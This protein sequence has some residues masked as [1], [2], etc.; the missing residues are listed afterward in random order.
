MKLFYRSIIVLTFALFG[1]SQ[2]ASATHIS[3]GDISYTCVGQDSFLVTL[4][5]FRDCAGVGL[6]TSQS[7]RFTST[8]G[9]NVTLSLQEISNNEISQLCPLQI[10]NSTCSPGGSWPGMEEHVYEGIVVLSPPCNSWTMTWSSCCRNNQISNLTNPGTLG[11]FLYNEMFSGVDTCNTSPKFTS[12]PIPYVCKNQVVNYNFGVYEPD[13]DS[14]VYFMSPGYT[15]NIT[16]TTPYRGT[17]TYLQPLPG[18][19]AVFDPTNGQLTFTPTATGVY[20][21]VVVIEEYDRLTGVAKGT[22]IRDIQVVVQNCTNNQPIVSS[23]GIK[24]FT[25]TGTQIDSNTI[26]LCIG[27]NFAFDYEIGDADSNNTITI[28]HNI[29]NALDSSANVTITNGNPAVIHVE[30]TAPG[31]F[32]P[33][34]SFSITGIDDACP[35]VG[36]VSGVINVRV[37]PSTYAGLDTSICVGTQ[38]VDLNVVGGAP[39]AW[40]VVSGS[41][42]DTNVNSPNFNMTCFNC[43]NPSVSPQVTTTY[44]VL[45]TSQLQGGCKQID[46][47]TVQ[48]FPNFEITMPNDTLICPIDSINLPV[49]ADVALTYSYQ[50]SYPYYMD[51]DT[52]ANPK[53]LP[54]APTNFRVS[55]TSAGG[56]VKTG[57]VFVDLTPSFPPN[58]TIFGDTVICVGDS[59]QLDVILGEVPLPFCG[60]STTACVGNTH[61]GIIGTGTTTN[62]LYSYPAPY[63]NYY[64]GSK[65][66]LLFTAAELHAM[67]MT[68]GKISAIYFDISTLG[69]TALFNNF[70]VKMGCTSSSDL[71]SGW[72]TGLTTVKNAYS[73][74]RSNGWNQ[75]AFDVEYDWNGT[76]N[77]VIEICYNNNNRSIAGTSLT[78]YTTTPFTSVR[79]FRANNNSNCGAT[80][81]QVS[82]NRPNIKIDFCSGANTDGFYYG[83]TPIAD[84]DTAT[85][86][87]PTIWPSVTTTYQV[88]VSD[89][90]GTCSDTIT[91]R[92]AVTSKFDARFTLL[93]TICI[94]GTVATAK[95]NVG[96]GVFRGT[97]IID[98]LLGEFDPANAGVG[99]WPVNY[100][101]SSASGGCANDS[102]RNV[103]VIPLPDASFIPL[104]VC[105]NGASDTL[106]GLIPGGTWSGP[107]IVDAVNGIFN[108]IGLPPGNYPVVYT[109][110]VPCTN[111]DTQL[112]R[113]VKPYSFTFIDST[114]NVCEESFIDVSGNFNVSSDPLQGAGP[115]ISSWSDANGYISTAGVFDATGVAPGKYYVTLSVAGADGTCGSS[116][117]MEVVVRAISYASSVQELVYCSNVKKAYIAISPWFVGAG[118]AYTQTPLAPLGATDTL[119]ITAFGQNGLF[120]ATIKGPGQW[121]LNISLTNKYGCVGEYID[122]INVLDTPIKPVYDENSYCEGDDVYLSASG[123]VISD[124]VYWYSDTK[125]TNLIG[126]GNNVYWGVAPNPDDTTAIYVF[127]T[128]NNWACISDKISYQL[129][130]HPTPSAEFTLTFKDTAGGNVIVPD[131]LS[132]VY[133]ETPFLI[134]FDA[135]GTDPNDTIT[136]FHHWEKGTEQVENEINRTSNANVSFNY[137]IP[138]IE[139]DGTIS[140]AYINQL[141]VTNRWGCSDT[142]SAFIYSIGTEAFF[143]VFTP[144]GDG[145]NDI[146]YLPVFGL[147]EYKVEIYN[148]WG[149]NVYSWEDPNEGWAGE[150][151]P[152]GVYYYIVTGINTDSSEYKKQGTVTLMGSGK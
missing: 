65:H 75:H 138:N 96:G 69:T 92:V 139:S 124:S 28:F 72:E 123:S 91:T 22:S 104:E 16:S 147:Q 89:T 64:W 82:S 149:K 94:N 6:G 106:V 140:D 97:G 76:S 98:S 25:G 50:W 79:Y 121:Q 70:E 141:V 58:I 142:A 31:G 29:F 11:T 129:P 53:V 115:V 133:G 132:P 134:N 13:G 110:T 143:N 85:I 127:L 3:G 86:S 55:V 26:E 15:N 20:V 52:I 120:D 34:S 100:S 90:F 109:L 84:I 57:D 10:P 148:R 119:N 45:S 73:H 37:F 35:V 68:T 74:R 44:A 81:G 66:Q 59:T 102:T 117:T 4:N 12:L 54:K 93:D 83:W 60:A 67:G 150:D 145:Q 103:E 122:T 14:I 47:I 95:P 107:G 136:W 36:I 30:W 49:T 63:S 128:Q 23:P 46:T 71:N 51:D 32:G 9:G 27:E 18:A 99:T 88:V 78:R 56:C 80:G 17:Y 39:F 61:S 108:P 151:Q 7:V 118:I 131:S 21:I 8:C 130:F 87:N 1:I 24:N 113:V 101:V 111:T 135:L 40:S 43:A 42:I 112:V 144:N 2:N 41:G 152:D 146:F 62:N 38:W 125:L 5:L 19:N 48:V 116:A 126:K 77:L 33:F 137:I 114:V 105:E